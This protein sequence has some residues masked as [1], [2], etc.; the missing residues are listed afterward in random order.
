MIELFVKEVTESQ[1]AISAADGEKI[2]QKLDDAFSKEEQVALDFTDIKLTIT[3]FLNASIGKL[4]SKYSSEQIR[5]LL[6]IRNLDKD[7]LPL[8][9][10]VV[11]RAKMR[12]K[13][14]YP[15]G[16]DKIDLVNED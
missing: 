13:K 12:F 8:L 4:Y 16:L 6:Q 1:R 15:T 14:E 10:L 7:E 5:N 2:F 11:D 9:K 3:A